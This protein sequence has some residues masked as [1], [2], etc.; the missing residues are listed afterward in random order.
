MEASLEEAKKD[1]VRVPQTVEEYTATVQKRLI[2]STSSNDYDDMIDYDDD[3]MQ[4]SDD[5]DEGEQLEESEEEYYQPGEG[6]S[7][8]A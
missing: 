3:Y 1:G 2:Q 7:G 6:D 8:M 5:D 4:S